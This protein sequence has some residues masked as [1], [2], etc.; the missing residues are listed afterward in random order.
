MNLKKLAPNCRIVAIAVATSGLCSCVNM[1]P[2]YWREIS[3]VQNVDYPADKIVGTW[4]QVGYAPLP[5]Q[6]GLG[7]ENKTYLNLK[8][9]GTGLCRHINILP[10][11]YAEYPDVVKG[12]M[13]L[14]AEYEFPLAWKHCGA[15][16][17]Q[18][19]YDASRFRV[20]SRPT[21]AT[22]N[23]AGLARPSMIRFHNGRLFDTTHPGTFVSILD[24]ESV[25]AHLREIRNTY[26]PTLRNQLNMKRA[27]RQ[28][29]VLPAANPS[30]S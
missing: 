25:E 2:A 10:P 13:D 8:S 5:L 26:T 3:Q 21:G 9:D 16:K 18:I 24:D 19:T 23:P 15:N 29:I 6:P 11:V 12:Q 14:M 1:D 4:L 7:S 27:L 22:I 28:Q 17:W 30:Q 20:V